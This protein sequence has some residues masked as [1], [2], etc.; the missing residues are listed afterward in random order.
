M[1]F[2]SPGP[3]LTRSSASG[4]LDRHDSYEGCYF[5]QAAAQASTGAES[6]GTSIEWQRFV[7]TSITGR[8]KRIDWPGGHAPLTTYHAL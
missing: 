3:P 2:S 7:P 6:P 8:V 4:A 1:M 5:A